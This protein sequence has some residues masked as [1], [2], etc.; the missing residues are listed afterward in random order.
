MAIMPAGKRK[1]RV[2][3]ERNAGGRSALGGK[4]AA[5]WQ[6]LGSRLA[7]V[8][9]GSSAERRTTAS[10]QAATQV[11]TFRVL[12]DSLTNGVG[13]RDRIVTPGDGLAWDITGLAP[14]GAPKATEIEFTATAVRGA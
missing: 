2:R 13:V 8:R 4:A 5:N 10:D 9:F 7:D 6:L 3:F 1:T 12:A 11:A 14:I